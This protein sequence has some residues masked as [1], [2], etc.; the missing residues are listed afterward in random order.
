M[1]IRVLLIALFIP[2]CF[3]G[4][5]AQTQL[6]KTSNRCENG[7]AWGPNYILNNTTQKYDFGFYFFCDSIMDLRY[8]NPPT[9]I[10]NINNGTVLIDSAQISMIYY[11][12]ITTTN[13]HKYLYEFRYPDLNSNTIALEYGVNE[14][15]SINYTT[16]NSNT[17]ATKAKSYFISIA[18]P[19]LF[20]SQYSS[21]DINFNQIFNDLSGNNLKEIIYQNKVVGIKYYC[22]KNSQ[23]IIRFFKS[24]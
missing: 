7:F 1:K 10:I 2:I 21:Q 15:D 24:K 3:I 4:V 18:D 14:I 19:D 9:R 20:A 16:G 6:S 23:E 13:L 12:F 22:S 17:V 11:E 8:L 5:S